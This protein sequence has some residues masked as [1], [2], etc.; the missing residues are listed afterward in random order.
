MEAINKYVYFNNDSTG[1]TVKCN[2]LQMTNMSRYILVFLHNY[3]TLY[4]HVRVVGFYILVHLRH[5]FT[6][7]L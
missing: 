3:F 5:L 2:L 6:S 4:M 1:T 7:F